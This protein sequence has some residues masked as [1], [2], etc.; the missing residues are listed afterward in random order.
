M[1]NFSPELFHFLKPLDRIISKLQLAIPF[2]G[3][4]MIVTARK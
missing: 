1:Q 3:G 4:E 2:Y